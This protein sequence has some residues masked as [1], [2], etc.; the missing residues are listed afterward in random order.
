MWNTWGMHLIG[1]GS[2]TPGEMKSKA[3]RDFPPPTIKT[4]IR[5]FLEL[6]GYYRQYI[7]MFSIIATPLTD[8]LTGRSKKGEVTWSAECTVAFEKLKTLLTSEPVLYAPDFT[9]KFVLQTDASE[10]GMGAVLSQIYDE[11]NEHPV[12]YLSKK[13]SE[14]E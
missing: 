5:A 11:K 7:T 9:K 13:F 1:Q 2:R 4:E 8:L 10:F 6:A 3:I 12:L 14:A